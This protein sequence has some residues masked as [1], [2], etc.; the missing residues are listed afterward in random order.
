MEEEVTDGTSSG[1]PRSFWVIGALT[2]IFNA[3]GVTNFI[4]QMSADAVAALPDLY[5]TVIESRPT[6]ATIAFG[7]AVFGGALGCILLLLRKSAAYA[8][9]V[10][11][12]LGAIVT[13]IDTIGT[14]SSNVAPAGFLVGNL[15]QLVVTGFLIWYSKRAGTRGW[16]S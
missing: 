11:S 15:T 16:T 9:F 8:V 13:M 4:S 14:V 2:L 3:A 7:A 12:L 6:W 10:V 5:R 1:V